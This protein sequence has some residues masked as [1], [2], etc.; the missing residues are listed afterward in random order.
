MIRKSFLIL[1]ILVVVL[2]IYHLAGNVPHME[3]M[4]LGMGMGVASAGPMM[5]YI[6]KVRLKIRERR[7]LK[8][9]AEI[10]NKRKES[11]MDELSE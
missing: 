3:S 8:E 11:E 9:L 7:S 5:Y 6:K 2:T 10:M 1:T 4:L